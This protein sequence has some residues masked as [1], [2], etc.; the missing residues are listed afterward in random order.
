MNLPRFKPL[1]LLAVL[2]GSACSAEYLQRY[3]PAID[4][5][6]LELRMEALRR[7]RDQ[8]AGQRLNQ[9]YGALARTERERARAEAEAMQRREEGLRI[10]EQAQAVEERRKEAARRERMRHMALVLQHME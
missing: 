7:E 2:L 9:Y 3:P 10:M 4:Y 1:L 8:L 6:R 5:D